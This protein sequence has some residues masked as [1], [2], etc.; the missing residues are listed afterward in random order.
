MHRQ[1]NDDLKTDL[2]NSILT[3]NDSS[4]SNFNTHILLTD[5]RSLIRV[6]L[7]LIFKWSET[8]VV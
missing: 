5:I 2:M 6:F 8:L 1:F 3:R 7:H 4:D